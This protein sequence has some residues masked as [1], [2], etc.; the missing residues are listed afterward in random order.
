M[1][2][3]KLYPSFKPPERLTLMLRA[4]ERGDDAEVDRLRD[5]CPRKTYTQP[6]IAFD[7]R[8]DLA[9]DMFAITCIDLRAMTAKLAAI[10]WA[11]HVVRTF[12]PL[13]HITATLGFIEGVRCAGGLD[14]AA[15][16]IAQELADTWRAFDGF[17]RSRIGLDGPAVFRAW[18]M[19]LGDDVLAMLELHKGVKPD[20]A[21]AKEYQQL[22][23]LTWDRRLGEGGDDG[24]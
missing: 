15:T 6:D 8:V 18:R 2:D 12:A 19:P 7:D 23:N 14:G 9:F 16:Q 4:M 24:R 11:K 10:D 20:A 5:S 17:C 3:S 1:V 22:L 13:N 21:K